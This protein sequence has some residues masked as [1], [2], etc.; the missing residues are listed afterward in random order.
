MTGGAS[1]HIESVPA[2]REIPLLPSRVFLTLQTLLL[3]IEC[4][5]RFSRRVQN[6]RVPSSGPFPPWFSPPALLLQTKPRAND[7]H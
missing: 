7:L 6:H 5:G 1:R 3:S 2:C 4:T